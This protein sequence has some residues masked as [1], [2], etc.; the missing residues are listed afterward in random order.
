MKKNIPATIILLVALTFSGLNSFAQKTTSNEPVKGYWMLVSNVHQKN[1]VTVQF[2]TDD[3][4]LM[5]HETLNKKLNIERSRVR[6]KLN[7]ALKESYQN[8]VANHVA[9]VEKD[10]IAKRL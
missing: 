7:D 6:S 10:L 4:T 9:P 8:W 5:Y 3:N 2:Y 1:L